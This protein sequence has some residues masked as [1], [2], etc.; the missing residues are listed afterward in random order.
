MTAVRAAHC[1][2]R[3]IQRRLS[4]ACL[5]IDSVAFCSSFPLRGPPTTTPPTTRHCHQY[6]FS[7]LCCKP[8][9]CT[10]SSIPMV[11][12]GT[13]HRLSGRRLGNLNHTR[14]SP[15]HHYNHITCAATTLLVL[16][17]SFHTT[18]PNIPYTAFSLS[19]SLSLFLSFSLYLLYISY[20]LCIYLYRREGDRGWDRTGENLD[21][22]RSNHVRLSR[23][24]VEEGWGAG[25]DNVRTERRR[26]HGVT[27]VFGMLQTGTGRFSGKSGNGDTTFWWAAHSIIPF[28]LLLMASGSGF[29]V[30]SHMG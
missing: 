6:D 18:T 11:L 26:I 12:R 3:R 22:Y 2:H 21:W 1:P 16:D 14:Q 28:A 19:L 27:G 13:S 23:R 17:P 24:Q 4:S 25:M 7:R 15:L 8:P 29:S 20:Y 30:L 10:A 5:V 9:W